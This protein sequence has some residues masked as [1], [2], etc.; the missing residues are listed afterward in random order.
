MSHLNRY[1]VIRMAIVATVIAFAFPTSTI[2]STESAL[3]FTVVL[4]QGLVDHPVTGRIFVL[5]SRQAA[6]EPRL[7][8]T[9]AWY[10]N[11]PDSPGS[12]PAM[13]A[14]D[15]KDLSAGGAVD[16][17]TGDV[18]FPVANL[19]SIP[20]GDYAVQ[21]LVNV[22]TRFERADGHVVWAH[23][24]QGEG[25]HALTSPGN[26]VSEPMHVHLDPAH[27][28]AIRLHL[29]RVLP[30]I[31]PR[32][33]TEFV[34]HARI[35]SRLASAFWGQAMDVGI[36][37][38]LPAGYGQ[39]PERRYPVLFHQ[40]HFNESAVFSM[41]E[42]PSSVA[43]ELHR[44]TERSKAFVDAWQSG[45]VPQMIVVTLQHP[46]PYYDTSYFMNSPNTG[47]WA[48]VF[49]SEIVPYIDAH[50]RTIAQP[51]A[52]VVA[53]LSSGGGIAAYLQVHYPTQL[54]GAWIFAPDPVDFHDF[55]TVNLYSDKN[56][57]EEPG[58]EWGMAP[59]RY[60]YRSTKG[61]SLQTIRRQTQL[62]D[63]MGS[64]ER[65]GEW[66]DN[67]DALYGPVGNDGYP[68]P[69]WNHQNG[70]IDPKVVAYWRANGADLRAYLEANWS[71]I[72][73]DLDGKLHF[74]AG[75][76]DN[77]FLNGGLYLLQDFLEHAHEPTISASFKYGRPMVGHSFAG[78][79]YDPFPIALLNDIAANIAKR[80]PTGTDTS[81]WYPH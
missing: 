78:V 66:M 26:L 54:G 44:W 36:T 52:R 33:D 73:P 10:N 23:K 64:H 9:S 42:P 56:A 77:Y 69:V 76:M 28:T 41:L 1:V 32:P 48:D 12:V 55:Y 8:D 4:D 3:R 24:D 57:Y 65:S 63:T 34:K 13:F 37:V 38:A 60:T 2:S 39:H 81:A 30:L 79:G 70:A 72:G 67:Y 49:F 6:G 35:T 47:P 59:P 61:Q 75:E 62:F 21:A 17:T 29:T 45:R 22:Y 5:I 27:V 58:H 53:G 50:F 46:T 43:A 7:A 15:A 14:I 16:V 19:R 74:A 80:V 40:G 71:R 11:T 25:Q 31:E 68:V 20:A 51:Y 18:G